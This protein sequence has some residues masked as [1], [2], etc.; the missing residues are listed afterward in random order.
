MNDDTNPTSINIS[1]P[2]RVP[3]VFVNQ[4]AGAGHH[5]SVVNLTFATAQ[6]TPT[7]D[8]KIDPDLVISSRLRMDIFCAEQLYA[9][10]GG[11]IQ[12]MT[13]ASGTTAN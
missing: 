1:D 10:L 12:Q 3:T 4:L 8:G 2:H 6:F 5:N 9:Q 7:H 11:I 13:K